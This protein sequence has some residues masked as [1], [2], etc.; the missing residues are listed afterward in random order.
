M[1]EYAAKHTITLQTPRPRCIPITRIRN[2]SHSFAWPRPTA[3]LYYVPALNEYT[4]PSIKGG[5]NSLCT[6]SSPALSLIYFFCFF[7]G[8]DD[9]RSGTCQNSNGLYRPRILLKAP[10]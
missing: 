6:L 1:S 7:F 2:L 8:E 4:P 5:P 9:S 10:F 3:P